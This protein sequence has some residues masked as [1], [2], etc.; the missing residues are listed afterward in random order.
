VIF[1]AAMA[2]GMYLQGMVA[3]PNWWRIA[4]RQP[5]LAA[6]RPVRDDS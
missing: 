6:L 3:R 1:V 4:A 2:A 5:A